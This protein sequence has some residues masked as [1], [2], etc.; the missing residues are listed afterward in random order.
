M[1]VRLNASD[2]EARLCR[3]YF[4]GKLESRCIK[5]DTI[6]GWIIRVIGNAK[7]LEAAPMPKG[8]YTVWYD[9]AYGWCE[10]E[11]GKITLIL[12]SPGAPL[13]PKELTE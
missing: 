11:W 10:Q 5:L 2:P 8:N 6:E 12:G 1:R 3:V 7:A 9:P 4:N 13:D